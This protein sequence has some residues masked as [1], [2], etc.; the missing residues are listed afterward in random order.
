[1]NKQQEKIEKFVVE[2][3]DF[4]ITLS[5]IDICKEKVSKNIKE[6][7]YAKQQLYAI[8]SFLECPKVLG[9]HILKYA[10][11]HL[12]QTDCNNF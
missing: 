7:N 11:V 12:N 5:V 9:I 4:N 6:L 3:K 10:N 2:V 1:M 8:I